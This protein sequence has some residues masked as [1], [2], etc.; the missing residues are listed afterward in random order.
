MFQEKFGLKLENGVPTDD[1]FQ[2][3]FAV[4]KPEQ[5][6]KC[7]MN[8]ANSVFETEINEVI[9][10]DGKTICGSQMDDYSFIHMVSAWASQTGIVLRQI[11]IDDKSN[12]I[13][14]VPK[15]L[16]LL[17]VENCIFTSDAMSY[18]KKTVEKII[19]K[20]CD[21]MICLKEN[22]EILH[23]DVKLYFETAL[24]EPKLYD[25][26]KSKSKTEKGHGRIETRQY[27]LF[28]EISDFIPGRNCHSDIEVF[29]FLK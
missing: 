1:T 18:Q 10:L 14:A 8:W 19:S 15:L 5:L 20:H 3:I 22:Q 27:F 17:E 4:I 11:R 12:E 29:A 23:E 6:E 9:S 24:T 16:D 26:V 7:F 25:F 28:T 2:R 21:Y 13:T